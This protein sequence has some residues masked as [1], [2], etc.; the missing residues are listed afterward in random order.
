MIYLVKVPWP[1][2]EGTDWMFVTNGDA[3]EPAP[4]QYKTLEEAERV[5]KSFN[6]KGV[7]VEYEL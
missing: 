4:M 2:E 7:V 3:A 6:D 1:S 5:A